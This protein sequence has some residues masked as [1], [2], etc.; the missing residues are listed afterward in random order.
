MLTIGFSAYDLAVMRFAFSPMQEIVASVRVLK[1]PAA[2]ALHVPWVKQVAPRVAAAAG[3]FDLLFALVPVPSWYI[4]D[5]VTPPPTTPVP[6]LQTE[7]A[8]LRRIEPQRVRTDL[9]RLAT[10]RDP[11]RQ[12]ATSGWNET[13]ART[14]DAELHAMWTDPS[15]GLDRLARQMN[16]YWSLAVSEYWPRLRSLLEADVVH[17]ARRLADGG[18]TSLFADLAPS[19]SWQDDQLTIAH[20]RFV[21]HRQLDGEGLLL[22]PSAFVWP[23]VFSST[24]PPWQPTLTYPAR[25][26]ATLWEQRTT[27]AAPALERVIGRSRTRLLLELDAPASTTELAYRTGLTPGAVSQ[28]LGLLRSAGL[29]GASRSGRLVLYFRTDASDML[30]TE[31]RD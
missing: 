24:M 30:L 12:S 25:G 3:A 1:D 28:H 26:V 8:D 16:D 20:P 17:R 14:D 19:V 29:V 4:P 18:P 6:D 11:A 13:K 7:L 31:V 5:F 23:T 21:G 2:H 9:D 27:A 15:A 10:L 22:V